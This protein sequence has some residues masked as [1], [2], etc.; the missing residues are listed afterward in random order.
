MKLFVFYRIYSI[1][2]VLNSIYTNT[3]NSIID[4]FYRTTK[5][6]NLNK[7]CVNSSLTECN[8]DS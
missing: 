7:F 6:N 4:K 5:P 2:I 8:I 1:I 3:L